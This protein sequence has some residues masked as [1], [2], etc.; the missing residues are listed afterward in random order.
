MGL[1]KAR[2]QV[3]VIPNLP[4]TPPFGPDLPWLSETLPPHR[5]RR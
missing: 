4:D 2:P 1:F 3:F 5:S